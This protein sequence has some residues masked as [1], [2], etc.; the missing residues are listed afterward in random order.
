MWNKELSCNWRLYSI[1]LRF[2]LDSVKESLYRNHGV[3]GFVEQQ[4]QEMSSLRLEDLK[5]DNP[6]L[7]LECET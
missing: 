7:T 4:V 1:N 2:S 5:N 3:L 6:G